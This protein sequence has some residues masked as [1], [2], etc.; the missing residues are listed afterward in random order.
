M[1]LPFTSRQ[2][3]RARRAQQSVERYFTD[4]INLYR[5][6]GWV[7][8]SD[9]PSLA[10]VEDC[11]SLELLLV[12]GHCLNRPGVRLVPDRPREALSPV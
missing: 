5:F 4:G 12:S 1:L 2:P 3:A 10:A 9:D 8:R 7:D 11:R 6:L